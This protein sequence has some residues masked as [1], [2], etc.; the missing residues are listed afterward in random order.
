M[1]QVQAFQDDAGR[2]HQTQAEADEANREMRLRALLEDVL[3]QSA[4]KVDQPLAAFPD[5]ANNPTPKEALQEVAMALS[6][7][8]ERFR[9]LLDD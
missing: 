8:R 7:N 2:L 6:Q 4:D 3:I 1:S 9:E 5:F